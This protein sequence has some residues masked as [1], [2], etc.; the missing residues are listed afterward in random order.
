MV[1]TLPLAVTCFTTDALSI[2]NTGS[3]NRVIDDFLF[4]TPHQEMQLA[5]AGIPVEFVLIDY[6]CCQWAVHEKQ[7][8]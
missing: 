8:D 5:D 7:C 4:L 2:V 1:E 3:P 6:G